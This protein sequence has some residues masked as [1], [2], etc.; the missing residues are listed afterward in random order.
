MYLPAETVSVSVA[1]AVEPVSLNEAKD[2]LRVSVDEDD[3]LI[4]RLIRTA[5]RH[6]ERTLSFR[7]LITQTLV[8]GLPNWPHDGVIRLPY[9]PLQ[10]VTSIAY[11]D[12]AG[13]SANVDS[14]VYGVDTK[15]DLIYLNYNQT[16]PTVS[17]RPYDP[18]TITWVAG[19]GDSGSDV[20][21]EYKAT[22][23]LLVGHLYENREAVV[24]G[25]GVTQTVLAQ[26]VDALG[27]GNRAY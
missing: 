15:L 20:D 4:Q 2:H 16:W 24:L 25:Q 14:A 13:N 5:R 19:Q 8:G 3:A 22:I 10:S 7:A 1:P 9:P 21:D 26:A 6:T 17:L 27:L 18:I 12:T 11:V 23:L